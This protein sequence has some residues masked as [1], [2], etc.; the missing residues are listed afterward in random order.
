M[1]P[2]SSA[3]LLMFAAAVV[4]SAQMPEPPDA[5]M[6]RATTFAP[7]VIRPEIAPRSFEDVAIGSHRVR[8]GGIV[9]AALG[10]TAG[11]VGASMLGVS[12]ADERPEGFAASTRS[13]MYLGS[14]GAVV[15]WV[16][17]TVL[18]LPFRGESVIGP[19]DARNASITGSAVGL[20]TGIA[21]GSLMTFKCVDC[22]RTARAA[23]GLA[24]SSASGAAL[25]WLLGRAVG[26]ALPHQTTPSP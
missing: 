4:L 20:A 16:T 13:A 6:M 9:G 5:A 21:A 10:L 19:N 8:N 25:G 2:A 3:L 11:L 18:M 12:S 23:N 1:K 15:G 24:L 22:N 14:S 17:G 7:R 26:L